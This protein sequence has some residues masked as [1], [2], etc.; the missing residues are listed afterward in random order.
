MRGVNRDPTNAR[1]KRI[2]KLVRKQAV[3]MRVLRNLEVPKAGE[4]GGQTNRAG[5]VNV[6]G[7]GEKASKTGRIVNRAGRTN[8][9]KATEVLNES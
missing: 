2:E 5:E 7:R 9:R 8:R 1:Q 6:C 4:D 3:H